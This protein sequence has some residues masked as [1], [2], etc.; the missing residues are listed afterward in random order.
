MKR[1]ILIACS[2]LAC[3]TVCG[4]HSKS[5][6]HHKDDSPRQIHRVHVKEVNNHKEL[7]KQESMAPRHEKHK[8]LR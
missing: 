8:K 4:C 2:A 6:H 7:H 1:A 5:K 3:A